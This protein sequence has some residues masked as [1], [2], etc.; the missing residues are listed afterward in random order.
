MAL[1]RAGNWALISAD[2]ILQVDFGNLSSVVTWLRSLP[3]NMDSILLDYS[4]DATEA[5]IQPFIF[6]ALREHAS[7]YPSPPLNSAHEE[8]RLL[9]LLPGQAEDDLVGQLD[10]VSLEHRPQYDAPS[11]TWG[12]SQF[13]KVIRLGDEH[14]LPITDNV[15]MALRRL[16]QAKQSVTLWID[17]ICINQSDLAERGKQVSIMGRIY[18]NASRVIIWLGDYGVHE[19]PEDEVFGMKHDMDIQG[20]MDAI[21]WKARPSW[22]TRAWVVQ[23]TVHAKHLEDFCWEIFGMGLFHKK[24]TS[25]YQPIDGKRAQ[26]WYTGAERQTVAERF[27]MI[28]G[29][30]RRIPAGHTASMASTLSLKKDQDCGD[31]RDKVYSIVS[32]ILPSE[33]QLLQPDY[34]MPAVELFARATYASIIVTGSF[35]ILMLRRLFQPKLLNRVPPTWAIDFNRVNSNYPGLWA[36]HRLQW[37]G[38]RE[39]CQNAASLSSDSLSLTATGSKFDTISQIW[40]LHYG[41]LD[42]AGQGLCDYLQA[43]L[44][45][46]SKAQHSPYSR[47]TAYPPAQNHC[48]PG[49]GEGLKCCGSLSDLI[50]SRGLPMSSAHDPMKSLSVQDILG[51]AFFLWSQIAGVPED[52]HQRAVD[53]VGGS[54]IHGYWTYAQGAAMDFSLF[55]TSSGFIGLVP[56]LAECGDK[57]A[58]LHG[59]AL[60]VVLRTCSEKHTQ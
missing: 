45:D 22:W 18:G 11:Y 21:Y 7:R 39:T 55:T 34:T 26:R 5:G 47:R 24:G 53:V 19:V 9:R 29:L 14:C 17:S 28:D 59:S 51:Y 46:I 35:Q 37:P 32:L 1:A 48:P 4:V 27:S 33:A 49:R 54:H 36:A 57:I 16:R 31:D 15:D 58:L 3:N 42:I 12:A 20:T 43:I 23:E 52:L 2:E 41:P 56:G 50:M 8:I 60:P 6:R 25:E 10:T 40:R 30:R 38:Q 44:D 13:K